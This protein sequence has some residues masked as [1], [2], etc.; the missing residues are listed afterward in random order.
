MII[1]SKNFEPKI[2]SELEHYYI[3]HVATKSRFPASKFIV[4]NRRTTESTSYFKCVGYWSEKDPRKEKEDYSL[5]DIKDVMIPWDQIAF[6]ESTQYKHK[7][8]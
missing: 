3:V 8:K 1:D 5:E 6:I 4:V 2:Q 7:Q